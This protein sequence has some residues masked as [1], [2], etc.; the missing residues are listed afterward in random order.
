[1][2][3]GLRAKTIGL[4]LLCA[5]LPLTLVAV[6]SFYSARNA[7]MRYIVA[8]LE[9]VTRQG[10][11]QLSAFLSGALNDLETWST[12]QSMQEV[13]IDDQGGEIQAEVER[14]RKR[15]SHFG[16]LLAMNGDGRVLAAGRP[17]NRGKDLA[18]T[19]L[20]DVVKLG[21]PIRAD[22][23]PSDLIGEWALTF[24]IPIF[25]DYDPSLPIGALVGVL[26]WTKIQD[27]LA[28]A[29][30]AGGPQDEDHL[31]AL[32]KVDGTV[33]YATRAVSEA[34]LTG[35]IAGLNSPHVGSVGR[36]DGAGE[37]FLYTTAT[38][39]AQSEFSVQD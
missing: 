31:L 25:A 32:L 9:S 2:R 22:V 35:L 38:L 16:E 13:L 37:P 27:R 10:T 26:D 28:T 19:P 21:K 34:R 18:A 12:L 17:K 36:V 6:S 11:N 4:T 5:L 1:M 24:A 33:L 8:D 15:Y 29:P 30:V 23:G 20:F 14:L 39:P 7:L 3:M